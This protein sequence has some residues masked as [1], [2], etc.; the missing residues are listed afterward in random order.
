MQGITFLSHFKNSQ[1]YVYVHVHVHMHT[2]IHLLSIGAKI[3]MVH[4][5]VCF[6]GIKFCEYHFL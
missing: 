4:V 3:G 1:H 5:M 2:Y 6:I